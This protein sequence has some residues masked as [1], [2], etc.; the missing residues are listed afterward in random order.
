MTDGSKKFVRTERGERID[1]PD[2]ERISHRGPREGLNQ[3]IDGFATGGDPSG[4]TQSRLYVLSG[5]AVTNPS[6]QQIRCGG[7]AAILGSRDTGA[8]RIGELQTE[9]DSEKTI[10]IT[11]LSNGSYGVFVRLDLQPDVPANRL[12]WDA[13]AAPPTE[14]VRNMLTRYVETWSIAIELVSPGAEW[15]RAATVV[16]SAGPIITITDTRDFFFEGVTP[17]AVTDVEWGD[18]NDRNA[19]RATYG[20]FGV[21]RFV[22]AVLKQ[23]QLIIGGASTWWQNPQA[24]TASGA[25]ARSLTQLNTEKLARNGAQTMQGDIIPDGNKTRDLGSAGARWQDVF[26]GNLNLDDNIIGDGT[27]IILGIA[28]INADNITSFNDL[29]SGGDV[30]GNTFQFNAPLGLKL[31]ISGADFQDDGT[32]GWAGGAGQDAANTGLVLTRTPGGAAG[33]AAPIH[34][35]QGAIITGAR[36]YG[37]VNNAAANM[38]IW[39]QRNEKA[40]VAT[41]SMKAGAPDYDSFINLSFITESELTIDEVVGVRTINNETYNYAVCYYYEPNAGG[42]VSGV[43][44][45]YEIDRA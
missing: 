41:D 31:S 21:R 5:F 11:S 34:L 19:D 10:D 44:I 18:T 27:V 30:F 26:A 25:G 17:Y 8:L 13:E 4:K 42:S 32:A 23:I 1:Q 3:V 6:G 37:D 20:L 9:G 38:R 36:W 15:L 16:K 45:D 22:R 33:A 12:A 2:M 29:F 14:T 35:P 39:I 43:E 40:T 24:G 7:G 28:T